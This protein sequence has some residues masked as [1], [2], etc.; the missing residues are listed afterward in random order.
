MNKIIIGL[1]CLCTFTACAQDH[2]Q[3]AQTLNLLN[4]ITSNTVLLN[5]HNAVIPLLNLDK[6]N[7]ASVNLG[8]NNQS[9]FDSLLNKYTKITSF[10]ANDYQSAATLNDLEDDLKYFNTVIVS[11]PS[12]A[13]NDIR[14]TSF[15]LSLSKN[16]QVIVSLF[17]EGKALAAFDALNVPIIWTDQN[18]PLSAAIIPQIIFGGIGINKKLSAN[19]SAKYIA[20]SGFETSTIRLKYTLPEDAGVNA[21]NLKEI[22]EIANEAIKAQATPGVVV[23]VA[24]NG[25]VIFNKAY[26]NHTYVN[27]IPE[28][29]SD[30]FDL[31]SLTKTT[32]TTPTVMRLFEEN[33]LNLDTNIG[34]YIPKA[35]TLPMNE[36]K[37]REVMLH[38][39]G[40]IPYIP[41][42]NS[43]TTSDYSRDSSA[44]YPTKAADNYYIRKNYFKDVMW[45][46]MLTS[47]I[48]TRGKYVY[49]DISMYVM[50]DIVERLSGV[51]LNQYVWDN[52]YKPL[53][54]QTAG[55]LPRNR[56]SKDQI[57][58]T[59]QDTYFRKTLL[60]G[61]VHDQGAALVGGVSGH[62]GLFASANDLAIIYQMLL[63]KGS[64]GGQQYFKPQTVDLFTQK[65]SDVSRR[66]LGFD[67]WDPDLTKKYPSELASPQTYGHTGYT[68]TC[69]W[70][71]PSRGLVYIFL[72]NRVHPSVT[73]KL[74]N[75]KIRGR[76]QD[77]INKAIDKGL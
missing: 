18:T 1:L 47:P 2:Q 19:F 61:Y 42:H 22:D 65:Q 62:A 29:V 56:F 40:F 50:K 15:I 6:Q 76:I 60:E 44:A 12:S 37:V 53:G 36:I 71:D 5:N 30:I 75:L 27:G 8:F 4:K 20:G 16:K 43:V 39:A 68:G 51:P 32:A 7:I 35:R 3:N 34:A 41:F 17:G 77:A 72:S 38:Q 21:D 14:I 33:K 66:G 26:G 58:P 23:L 70:V 64:Y 10:S 69:V 11:L 31:A 46:K 52:F 28:K 55:F 25:K 13:S 45:P 57:V 49:S 54:M 63:N 48:K 59:E 9:V 67:R 73:E 24:K 74:G